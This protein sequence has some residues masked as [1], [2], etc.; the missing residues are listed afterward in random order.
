[1]AAANF[2]RDVLEMFYGPISKEEEQR[3]RPPIRPRR[4]LDFEI[5]RN[6]FNQW[7]RVWKMRVR[8]GN[9][10]ILKFFQKTKNRFIDVCRNEVQALRSV[11]VQFGLEVRCYINRNDEVEYTFHYFNRMQSIVLNEHNI[12]TL[13]HILNQLVDEVRGEIQAWSERGSGW[14]VD[15]ILE[16]IVN[17]AQYQPVNGGTYIPLPEKLKNKKAIINIQKRDNECLRW[18]LRAAIFPAPRSAQVSRTSSYPTN[19]GLNFTEIDFPTPV[20]QIDKLERQNPNLVINVFGGD[21]KQVI[22]HRISEK[23]GGTPRINL[24]ANGPVVWPEPTQ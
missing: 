19:G 22:V 24:I 20:S 10:D 12:D 13:N 18:A 21:K 7:L 17:V 14:V 5:V 9:R 16:A 4:R 8:G 2:S 23:D 15:E 11:K 3:L 1:M 6:N